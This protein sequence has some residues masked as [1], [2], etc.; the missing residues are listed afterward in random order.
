MFEVDLE[1]GALQRLY[2]DPSHNETQQ[3]RR[4]T[5]VSDLGGQASQAVVAPDGR[6]IAFA[7]DAPQSGPYAGKGGLYVAEFL[8]DRCAKEGQRRAMP[9]TCSQ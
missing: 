4:L 7:L 1:T 9:S 6:R 8:S 3:I 5:D 2:R